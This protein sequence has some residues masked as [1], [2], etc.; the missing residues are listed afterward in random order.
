MPLLDTHLILD[1]CPHCSI[2]KPNL[3]C[4]LTCI[5]DNYRNTNKRDWNFY[6]CARCGGIVTASASAPGHE[7][8]QIFPELSSI[9]GNI[10]SRAKEYL[11]QAVDSIHSPAGAIMLSASS[12]DSMLKEK[13]Y[14]K[15]DLYT[16][17]NKAAEEHL[18]TD[19]MA[20]WAHQV[21]LNANDQRHADEEIELPNEED[22]QKTIDFTL[23]L[24]EFLFVLPSRVEKGLEDTEPKDQIE[25]A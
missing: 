11:E 12:V 21:R 17:I 18:I 8:Q 13:G 6:R 19:E 1:R 15:G 3:K 16:R 14:K 22:A 20:T 4:I 7:T 23:A 10:P 25:E 2:D 5:T 24:A 9:D